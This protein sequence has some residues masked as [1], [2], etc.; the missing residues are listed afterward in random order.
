MATGDA[1]AVVTRSTPEGKEML[2]FP[3]ALNPDLF[4][5]MLTPDRPSGGVLICPSLSPA[6]LWSEDRERE[7][8]T[9]V[10]RR[11]RAALVFDYRGEGRSVAPRQ[12]GL[13]ALSH[14]ILSAL[15]V[16]VHTVP[17]NDVTVVGIGAGSLLAMEALTDRT[18]P[19]ASWGSPPD[20][21]RFVLDLMRERVIRQM[22]FSREGDTSLRDRVA[23]DILDEETGLGSVDALGFLLPAVLVSELSALAGPGLSVESFGEDESPSS[24]AD[25]ACQGGRPQ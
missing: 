20:G 10:V 13:K 14:D 2:G 17:A 21:R 24:V 3:S 12:P 6:R 4:C 1:S 7:L 9:E 19:F 18:M 25:W 16:L 15:D 5:R 11:R 8:L 22:G 23:M